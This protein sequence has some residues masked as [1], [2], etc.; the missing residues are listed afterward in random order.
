MAM[1]SGGQL[2]VD[3]LIEKGVNKVFSL[4][5]GHIFPF[6]ECSEGSCLEIFAT[7]HEQAAVFMAEAWG[8]MTRKPGVA[9]VTAGPGFSNSISAIANAQMANSP[10]LL[11]AGVVGLRANEKL[12]LQDMRQL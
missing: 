3:A 7:R 9:L 2:A 11:I 4:S 5:G 1:I 10:L 12:D 8:R 6:Y